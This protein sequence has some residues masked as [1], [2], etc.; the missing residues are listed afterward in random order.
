MEF[1]P[2]AYCCTVSLLLM[3]LVFPFTTYLK[4]VS[5]NLLATSNVLLIIYAVF[6]AR[7][8]WGLFLLA[9]QMNDT[10]P[11][12]QG[13]VSGIIDGFFV[14]Q[15]LIILLP[16]L[17]I[18]KRWRSNIWLSA[19]L[20]VLVYWNYPISFWNTYHL[21]FKVLSYLCLFAATYAL[22][23]LRNQLPI[24]SYAE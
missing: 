15:L 2:I 23:W 7:Q 13:Q 4:R 14:R 18:F 1:I 5:Y 6:L 24:Q 17:F 20:L 19:V 10:Y 9:R 16:V 21:L 12:M 11:G 8:L 22:I 3:I